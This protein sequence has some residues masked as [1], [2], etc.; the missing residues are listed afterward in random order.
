MQKL[1]CN[2]FLHQAGKLNSKSDTLLETV[3]TLLSNQKQKSDTLGPQMDEIGPY[4]GQL[5]STLPKKLEKRRKSLTVRRPTLDDWD[6]YFQYGTVYC[7]S[8]GMCN[9][10]TEAFKV[11]DRDR[12]QADL[13]TVTEIQETLDHD[14]T[15]RSTMASKPKRKREPS[16]LPAPS[17]Y[18]IPKKVNSYNQNQRGPSTSRAAYDSTSRDRSDGSRRYDRNRQDFGDS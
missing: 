15:T 7:K 11:T 18:R 8:W 2:E 17:N 6:H 3:E 12:A 4:V 14:E 5:R 16:P 13:D 1:T 10:Q 9:H